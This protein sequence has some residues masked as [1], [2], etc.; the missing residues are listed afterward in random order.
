[1]KKLKII[2]SIVIA[3][4]IIIILLMSNYSSYKSSFINNE[5]KDYTVVN[6]I[7]ISNQSQEDILIQEKNGSKLFINVET[8]NMYVVRD[9]EIIFETLPFAQNSSVSNP[10]LKSPFNISYVPIN[11][12]AETQVDMYSEAIDKDSYTIDILDDGVLVNYTLGS[13]SVS[14]SLLPKYIDITRFEE[15]NLKLDTK[16]QKVLASVYSKS[17]QQEAYVRLAEVK[18]KLVNDIYRILYTNVGYT[19]DELKESNEKFK[20]KEEKIQ[21]VLSISLPLVVKLNDQGD[22]K[23]NLDMKK[24]T[25]SGLESLTRIDV[26][27]TAM[28][29]DSQYF[30]VPDG[31]GAIINPNNQ[32]GFYKKEFSTVE[33]DTNNSKDKINEQQL[34]LPVFGNNKTMAYIDNGASSM[35]LVADFINEQKMIFPSIKTQYISNVKFG[36]A[37]I[38]IYS[39]LTKENYEITYLSSTLDQT[40]MQQADKISSYT[41]SKYDLTESIENPGLNLEFIGTYNYDDFAFGI[42]KTKYRSATTFEKAEEI[43]SKFSGINVTDSYI[44][45][46]EKGIKQSGKDYKISKKNGKESSLNSLVE[47][48]NTY[49]G[50]NLATFYD[51]YSSSF[52]KSKDSTYTAANIVSDQ[53]D[54]LKSTLNPNLKLDSYNILQPQKLLD[55]AQ[56]ALDKSRSDEMY[57]RD[58][59]S[60]GIANFKKNQ[61]IFPGEAN[62]YV[63]EVLKFLSEKNIMI[64]NTSVERGFYA[65]YVTDLPTKSSNSFKFD[66]SI[67][68]IQ[69]VYKD[70]INYSTS[71]INLA[72]S[73]NPQ[74]EVLKAIETNSDLKYIISGNE[75]IEFKN[76]DYSYYYSTYFNDWEEFIM[77]SAQKQKEFYDKVG[78]TEIINHQTINPDIIKV[79]YENGKFAVFNYSNENAVI[80][81]LTIEVNNYMIGGSVNE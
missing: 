81:G 1:M 46:L 16:S 56:T 49:L 51:K 32:S 57:I 24:A 73:G 38:K 80:D 27:P 52:N 70:F 62:N 3:S 22:L 60:L 9:G 54:V 23:A 68:F 14:L 76:S 17:S 42:P 19:E 61:S 41:S 29:R 20:V 7:D 11:S 55:N 65:D 77:Q 4:V 53:Q 67:P 74:R 59:G 13:G 2:V 44:G 25:V 64:S 50:Y 30:L 6:T 48:N 36:T 12:V 43:L 71:S 66:Y 5:T 78:T 79:T 15:I 33:S 21:E 47:T 37:D 45:W 63:I 31:S 69:L 28:S 10:T 39:D 58:L 26:L 35:E 34:T 75:S 8:T 18:P 72:N 40:Y